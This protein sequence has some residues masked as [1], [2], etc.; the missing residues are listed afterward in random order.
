MRK[1]PFEFTPQF[2]PVIAGNHKPSLRSVDPAIRGRLHLVPFTV[3]IPEAER[4][5]DLPEK[6]KAE[7]PEILQ[8]MIDGCLDY[9]RQGLVP[10]KAVTDAT[11]TYLNEQD[12]FNAWVEECC[13]LGR[14]YE[15]HASSLF[16]S[17]KFWAERA[18]EPVG[19]Q[20]DFANRLTTLPGVQAR[21]TN[22]DR[23]YAGVRLK[24]PPHAAAS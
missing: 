23:K 22:R 20:R 17:W 8:W 18:N 2:T 4:D 10:P 13:D 11:D 21:R 3:T 19:T 15:D 24:P 5:P 6:L 16:D 7:G 14:T 12:Q 9:R 1:D